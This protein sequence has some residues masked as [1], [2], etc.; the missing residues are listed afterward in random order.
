MKTIA[1]LVVALITVGFSV[2]TVAADPL[3]VQDCIREA[4]EHSPLL[5]SNQHLIEADRA[6]IMKKKGATL[7][8]FSTQ[9]QGYEV[10][11]S[12][13][14]AFTPLGLFEPASGGVLTSKGIR[15][16]SAHWAPVGLEEVGVTYPL[17]YE[18]S[19][20][21]LNDSPSVASARAVM[22][23]QQLTQAV[24]EQ[25]VI[26]DVLTAYIYV[27]GYR[28]ELATQRELLKASQ[29]QLAITREQV[30]LGLKLE[31]DIDVAQGQV[32]QAQQ[33]IESASQSA[34]TFAAE[35]AEMIGR[36]S[37]DSLELQDWWPKLP[38]LP[39]QRQLVEEVVAASP[40]LSIQQAKIDV[41]RQQLKVDQTSLLPTATLNTSF[42][43][44]QDLE[45]FNGNSTHPRPTLFLS[46]LTVEMPI[47]DFGQRASAIRESEET[48][49]SARDALSEV[50]LQ[51]QSSITQTYGTILVDAQTLAT[52]QSTYI[53]EDRALMLAR[54]QHDEGMVDELGLAT[55]EVTALEAKVPVEVEDLTER[56]QYASLQNLTA[57][58]WRLVR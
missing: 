42:S 54:A 31:Q 5:S 32:D 13:V 8:Y 2:P 26:F 11:G 10:N 18:G 25:K 56:L 52:M 48:L 29:R 27:I 41:A 45:Y 49:L 35:L 15:F 16:P 47:F 40:A 12:P 6:D 51:L 20:L 24:A 50:K 34:Q 44:A 55:A 28:R 57:G 30:G 17:Y 14:T 1:M 46:Y 9:L 4:L 19:I 21:G 39:P 53:K 43:G 38:K 58:V 22:T 33:G 3:S 36:S 7:P 37:D 23:Q